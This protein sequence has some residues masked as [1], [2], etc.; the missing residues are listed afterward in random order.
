MSY[1]CILLILLF[2]FEVQG[3]V[4]KT[5]DENGQVIYTD[6]KPHD[7]GSEEMELRRL[8]P[9][10]GVTDSSRSFQRKKELNKQ[11]VPPVQLK[12]VEPEKNATIR[13][14]G[15]FSIKLSLQPKLTGSWKVRLY[16][17]G[18][19]I[20]SKKSLFFRLNNVARGTHQIKVDAINMN[21]EVVA[22]AANT[23]HVHRNR[24]R[25]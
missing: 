15:T 20:E 10:K 9:I 14:N 11:G 6:V 23:V 7:T 4:Y 13:N 18:E 22:S 16:L 1:F 17:D 25:P 21:G 5:V 2:S 8:T 12:I 24:V 3:A 19:L